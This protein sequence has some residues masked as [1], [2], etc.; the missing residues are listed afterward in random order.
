MDPNDIW[1]AA[2]RFAKSF[3]SHCLLLLPWE[4]LI[5]EQTQEG[6]DA[7]CE[8]TDAFE[9][10]VQFVDSVHWEQDGHVQLEAAA[11]ALYIR[12][13][14]LERA[15]HKARRFKR[16]LDEAA[17]AHDF[18]IRREG[19]PYPNDLAFAISR[20]LLRCISS[21]LHSMDRKREKIFD[22]VRG[23]LILEDPF[24]TYFS[25]DIRDIQNVR[26]TCKDFCRTSSHL[27]LNHVDIGLRPES[28]SQLEEISR[29]PTI[30][31]GVQLVRLDLQSYYSELSGDLRKFAEMLSRC[32]EDDID[33]LHRRRSRPG[34]MFKDLPD[35]DVDSTLEKGNSILEAWGRFAHSGEETPGS[36]AF[37]EVL[38]TA[39]R[40]YQR[41]FDVQERLL[42]DRGFVQAFASAIARMPRVKSLVIEE[43]TRSSRRQIPHRQPFYKAIHD[44]DA[45]CW[46]YVEALPTELVDEYGVDVSPS[47]DLALN[48]LAAIPGA[49][50]SLRNIKIDIARVGD[51]ALLVS[52][53]STRRHLSVLSKQLVGAS[54]RF[55]ALQ[56]GSSANTQ[57]DFYQLSLAILDSDSL[58]HIILN[59]GDIKSEELSPFD[60][61]PILN[62]QE[63]PNLSTLSLHGVAIHATELELFTN[64]LRPRGRLRRVMKSSYSLGVHFHLSELRLLSGTWADVLDLL[65]TKTHP[66]SSIQRPSGAE[67][68]DMTKEEY[69]KVFTKPG[70]GFALS[71]VNPSLAEEYIQQPSSSDH[72]NPLRAN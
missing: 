56:Q 13:S 42:K 59:L 9:K 26:L 51:A 53:P 50:A 20:Q 23:H 34:L 40:E 46:T 48:S 17:K 3:H 7:L 52:S 22:Y 8:I 14:V 11:D 72:P 35:G 41:L 30:G 64:P 68:E 61:G 38:R 44:P 57:S 2:S 67:C 27:L 39:H 29:H 5:E 33:F 63:R 65:R 16:A 49:G 45:L 28:L 71:W 1:K 69:D 12:L 25:G 36:E 4:Y 19:G 18:I 21:L 31:K 43:E 6:Y 66:Y 32:L 15:D 24:S 62:C 10:F 37:V 54:I 47:M 60:I 70:N 55:G 58:E